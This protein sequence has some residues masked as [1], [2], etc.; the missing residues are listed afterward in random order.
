VTSHVSSG[1]FLVNAKW[2]AF[3]KE[4]HVEFRSRICHT[5][6]ITRVKQRLDRQYLEYEN[7]VT[8]ERI[9]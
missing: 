5:R 2:E 8:C 6:Y 9:R 3:C 7:V 1:M 4:P